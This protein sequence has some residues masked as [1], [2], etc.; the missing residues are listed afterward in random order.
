[1]RKMSAVKKQRISGL[2]LRTNH[3]EFN[4]VCSS[5]NFIFSSINFVDFSLKLPCGQLIV[6]WEINLKHIQHHSQSSR[7]LPV[8][9]G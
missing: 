1:M 4:V 6:A 7:L 3:Q 9:T 8:E 5:V 2:N